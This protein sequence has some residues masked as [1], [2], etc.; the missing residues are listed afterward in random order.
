MSRFASRSFVL[1]VALAGAAASLVYVGGVPAA[2]PAPAPKPVEPIDPATLRVGHS[3]HMVWNWGRVPRVIACRVA[4]G[5]TG[6][7]RT[8]LR[9]EWPDEEDGGTAW[10]TV[11]N[12]VVVYATEGA[13]KRH[14]AKILRDRAAELLKRAEELEK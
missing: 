10:T 8:G 13:A 11:D 2:P 12:T 7:N 6:I 14:A 9:L 4:H 5:S 1:A 3:V